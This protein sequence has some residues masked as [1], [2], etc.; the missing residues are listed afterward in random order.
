MPELSHPEERAA[1]QRAIGLLFSRGVM[2]K[3]GHANVSLRVGESRMLLTR[4]VVW[5]VTARDLTLV[6]F[7][8][9]VVE[10]TLDPPSAEIVGMHVAAYRAD[11][12]TSSV[13]HTHA[14]FL[15]AFALAG[16]ELPVHYEPMLRV[17]QHAPVP[18]VPWAPRGSRES[19]AG[20]TEALASQPDTRAVLLANHG[21]L[22]FG[23][24]ADDAVLTIVTLEEA[25]EREL[26]ALPLGGGRPLPSGAARTVAGRMAASGADK[27]T[28]V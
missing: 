11:A 2:S 4:G 1:L 13:V 12:A 18:V 21:P 10:G 20:I 14:P 17:R 23:S 3:S 7:E 25:A 26:L 5:D 19:V 6:D 28:G 8:M 16:R 27:F 15:S 9:G 22:V 24:S